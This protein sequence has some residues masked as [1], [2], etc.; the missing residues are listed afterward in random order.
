MAHAAP[1][2]N[3]GMKFKVT[4]RE[5][6]AR[7]GVLETAHGKIET[8][9][10]MPVGTLATVKTIS[11]EELRS[12]GAQIVLSNTY[13]LHL[14]PGEKLIKRA[15]GLHQFMSWSGP[16]LT[17]SGGFQVFSLGHMRKVTNKGAIFQSHLDG[18]RVV[19]TP[20]LA[21][22]IQRDLGSD[23][24]MVLDDVVGYPATKFRT[25]EA[26]VRTHAW[27]ERCLLGPRLKHQAVFGIVQ[28]GMFPDLRL[29]SAQFVSNQAVDGVAIGG[30]SVGE[31]RAKMN[32]MLD[33]VEPVLPTNKPRYLMGVGAPIDLLE[34]VERGMDMFDCVLPTRIARNG[35]V[36]T[37][38][39]AVNLFNAKFKTTFK[40]ID[41]ACQCYTC[42]HFTTAYLH[43]LLKERE[44]LGIRLT[45]IHNLHFLLELMRGVRQSIRQGEFAIFKRRF[46]KEFGA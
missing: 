35:T 40:P 19:L 41:K 38:R 24:A 46:I 11:P 25:K 43:H 5:K 32:E 20:E 14:R 22:Q 9:V 18:K 2:Y 6:R 13:H 28:G 4:H 42:Q 1:H 36:W 7:A 21:M 23:I 39:G 27:L 30:L 31:P 37:K 12:V 3:R 10:F 45:T 44:V 17:D 26:M 29:E 16:I 33:L 15:G 34:A 8:P